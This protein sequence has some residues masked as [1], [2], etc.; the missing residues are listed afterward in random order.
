MKSVDPKRKRVRMFLIFI[1]VFIPIIYF[2]C[3]MNT[4][5][6]AKELEG[7]WLRSDGTYTIK[8]TEVEADGKLTAEYF[9]PGPI[10]VAESRWELKDKKIQI[11]VKM[12]DKNYP[13]SYYKLTYIK[14]SK[15]L[16]GTYYQAME[17]Q[18]FDVVFAKKHD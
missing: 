9:N 10:H 6:V 8:I 1:V 13:G 17:R 18:T 11:F 4:S 14:K 12:Q 16:V 2:T 7:S 5:V 15:E 3:F